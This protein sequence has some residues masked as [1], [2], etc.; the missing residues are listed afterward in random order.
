MPAKR[1]HTSAKLAAGVQ[2]CVGRTCG[3]TRDNELRNSRDKM[4]A[5]PSSPQTVP[6]WDDDE[7]HVHTDPSE[8]SPNISQLAAK[9][10]TAGSA[11]SSQS[12]GSSPPARPQSAQ[13][14]SLSR[15][16]SSLNDPP[17]GR[18]SEI[19]GQRRGSVVS[20][21]SGML[22]RR[23][24]VASKDEPDNKQPS[25]EAPATSSTADIDD[26]DP[27]GR[28]GSLS[29]R[30]SSFSLE[31]IKER[32]QERSELRRQSKQFARDSR[33]GL[34]RAAAEYDN[35]NATAKRAAQKAKQAQNVL[36]RQK[37]EERTMAFLAAGNARVPNDG[38]PIRTWLKVQDELKEAEQ[39]GTPLSE[40][41]R[42]AI[43]KM[44]TAEKAIK[45]ASMSAKRAAEAAAAE[46]AATEKGA[47]RRAAAESMAHSAADRA[48]KLAEEAEKL[49]EEA[50]KKEQLKAEAVEQ[51][52]EARRLEHL[53]K[54]G[55]LSNFGIQNA[56]K[57]L[58]PRASMYFGQRTKSTLTQEDRD[59]EAAMRAAGAAVDEPEYKLTALDVLCC[60]L[61]IGYFSRGRPRV[62]PH[63]DGGAAMQPQIVAQRRR[64][65]MEEDGS[66]PTTPR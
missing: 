17:E 52:R 43:V 37:W 54:W 27:I 4:S 10:E 29:A 60:C 57:G 39:H 62:A 61:P 41:A 38:T 30:R 12:S 65:S 66:K 22:G 58:F 34:F 7:T 40:S 35:A 8:P 15:K 56:H 28:S 42:S 46:Y 59:A 16:S 23:G 31:G 50:K 13:L 53:A 33:E 44:G 14:P 63:P 48:R 45:N 1:R 11:S 18:K 49:A 19:I 5:G 20:R 6:Q 47:K 2:Y 26:T 64:T 24:S 21:L 9:A 36:A 55:T 32:R 51:L 3:S 25:S